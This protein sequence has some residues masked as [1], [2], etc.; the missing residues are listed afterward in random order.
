MVPSGDALADTRAE[1]EQEYASLKRET[2]T[3]GPA[4]FAFAQKAREAGAGSLAWESLQLAEDAG[5][6]GPGLGIE[7]ARVKVVLED[8][9]GA[10]A[11]LRDLYEQG[12][13]AVGFLVADSDISSLAG[14][15]GYDALIDEMSVQAYPCRHQSGFTDFDFWI[16]EWDVHVANGTL[17]GSNSIQPAER[18]CV[19]LEQWT[20]A[21]GGT[22][23]SI[24]Y[25]DMS[26]GEW[27]QIW[28]AEGGTQI[29]I[30]GGL[31]A[32]GMAM[33]GTIHYVANG[34]TAPFRA[35]WTPLDDGRV[36]QY[37]E[38][39][40]DD[41]DTWVPWFEGFYSRKSQ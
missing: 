2:E 3:P 30:R 20:S 10:I 28:N 25:L 22:G 23:M 6:T 31:T 15:P 7:S 4:W 13:T 9:E 16:G 1:L 5:F 35:L 14:R 32:E 8:P 11:E 18:G 26:S 36:R 27:V 19:L 37:F 33:E 34:T 41:G 12:F 21:T 40:N 24:N 38:Q 17:A 29:N 39:S